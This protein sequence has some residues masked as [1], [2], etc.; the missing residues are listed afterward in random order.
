MD[1]QTAAQTAAQLT[2]WPTCRANESNESNESNETQQAREARGVK[3]SKN[4]D[5]VAQ[6]IQPWCSPNRPGRDAGQPAGE[7]AGH[8]GSVEPAGGD[9]VTLGDAI[10]PRLE[11]H[12]GDVRDGH[13]PGREPARAVGPVAEAGAV[14]S[15]WKSKGDRQQRQPIRANGEQAGRITEANFWSDFRII[16]TRDGKSRRIPQFEPGV[17]DVVNEP[18]YGLDALRNSGASEIETQEITEAIGGFPLAGKIPGRVMLL[19]GAG[20]AIVPELAAE[21]IRSF[22]EISK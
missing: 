17:F 14:V 19:K 6:M 18:A 2:P 4:L 20:N 9:G 8:G 3:A 7:A 12:S 16:Q 22:M 13:Q 10:E 15:V 21:F 11:G 1:L 5:S